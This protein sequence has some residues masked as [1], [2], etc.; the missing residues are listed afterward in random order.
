M[1]E[2]TVQVSGHV[3]TKCVRV[4]S[5]TGGVTMTPVFQMVIILF[6][7]IELTMIGDNFC[8]VW[9]VTEMTT[10][11]ITVRSPIIA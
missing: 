7:I 9:V 3:N 11:E 1:S 5:T 2:E 10:A 4:Q 6:Q 8:S